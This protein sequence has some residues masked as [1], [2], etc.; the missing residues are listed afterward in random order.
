[1]S[2]RILARMISAILDHRG[3]GTDP[4]RIVA[5]SFNESAATA[6]LLGCPQRHI[7]NQQ[8]NA[9]TSA[10]RPKSIC[11]G[12]AATLLGIKGHTIPRHQVCRMAGALPARLPYVGCCSALGVA[13]QSSPPA[14]IEGGAA[15]EHRA[16]LQ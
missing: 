3:S 7:D 13:P 9:L 6:P 11:C 16:R 4:S 5:L 8:R 1:M 2:H 14:V 10:R 15:R 12:N